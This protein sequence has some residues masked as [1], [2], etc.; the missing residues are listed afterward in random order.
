LE[1]LGINGPFLLAQIVNFALMFVLLRMFLYE[2]I[3]NMLAQR[4]ERIRESLSAAETAQ[5][6]V[7][8][9]TQ[10]SEEEI[11]RARRE[12]QEIIARAREAAEREAQTRAAEIIARAEAEAGRMRE[13]ISFER[14]QMVSEL[15]GQVAELSL[16]VAQKVIG[17]ALNT[18]DQRKLVDKFL[19]EVGDLK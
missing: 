18:A 10:R 7:Q 12:G 16:A 17:Q 4:R 14:Q 2:P 5:A 6:E 11:A 9:T 13:E 15:R 8:A 1:A 19:A 3:L